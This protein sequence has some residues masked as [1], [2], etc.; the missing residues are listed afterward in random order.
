[1]LCS[2]CPETPYRDALQRRRVSVYLRL[3]F[4][5]RRGRFVNPE[6]F[7]FEQCLDSRVVFSFCPD[8]V[9]HLAGAGD[10]SDFA[11]LRILDSGSRLPSISRC[12]SVLH[13]L[14]PQ[15]LGL[16]QDKQAGTEWLSVDYL[17]GSAHPNLTESELVI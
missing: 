3:S 11:C 8:V 6:R 4:G 1:M 16:L 15:L 12:K 17:G 10:K 13:R 7:R 5:C 2:P 9:I 14:V